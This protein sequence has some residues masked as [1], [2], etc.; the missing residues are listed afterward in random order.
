MNHGV[1]SAESIPPFRF[2]P[3]AFLLEWANVLGHCPTSMDTNNGIAGLGY[4]RGARCS[5]IP[6]K[7]TK[8]ISPYALLP[9]RNSPATDVVGR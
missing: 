7:N 1:Q 9:T 4:F 3:R 6:M 2:A 5:W 8:V